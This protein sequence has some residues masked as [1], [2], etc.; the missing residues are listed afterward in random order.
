M[1]ARESLNR[2][3]TGPLQVDLRVEFWPSADVT[4]VPAPR[5]ESEPT[6][7]LDGSNLLAVG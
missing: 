2:A 6:A 4:V 7:V 5:D 1:I 3:V